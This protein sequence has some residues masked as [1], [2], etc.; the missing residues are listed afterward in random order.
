MVA[1]AQTSDARLNE[2]KA[3]ELLSEKLGLESAS[4]H[5]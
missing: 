1:L 2:A 4:R 5:D 3:G